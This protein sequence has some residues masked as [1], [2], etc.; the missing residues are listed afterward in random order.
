MAQLSWSKSFIFEWV[1]KKSK[2]PTMIE[3]VHSGL[4]LKTAICHWS[5]FC[6][7]KV[8]TRTRA[9]MI[10]A[11]RSSSHL[12]RVTIGGALSARTR[13]GQRKGQRQWL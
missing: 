8:L 6:W 3:S 7:S 12:S 10:A 4:Q 13:L 5:S 11:A 1:Y 2:G 9:P